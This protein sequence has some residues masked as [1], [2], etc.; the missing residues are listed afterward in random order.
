MH[1]EEQAY[2]IIYMKKKKIPEGS[3]VEEARGRDHNPN[4]SSSKR[5]LPNSESKPTDLP[6]VPKQFLHLYSL[7]SLKGAQ[8]YI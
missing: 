5:E 7:Q 2:I 1:L 4:G 3:G 6:W 8:L